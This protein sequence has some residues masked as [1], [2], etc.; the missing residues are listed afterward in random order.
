[1]SGQDRLMGHL[2]ELSQLISQIQIELIHA[3]V[4]FNRIQ[5]SVRR[6]KHKAKKPQ[7]PNDDSDEELNKEVVWLDSDQSMV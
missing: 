3:E 1:M 7:E 4:L 6:L 5:R 2:K